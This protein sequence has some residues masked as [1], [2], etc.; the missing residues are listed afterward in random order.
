M[1]ITVT[2]LAPEIGAEISGWR[3]S[4]LVNEAVAADCKAALDQYGVLVYREV[5]I[6]DGDL[7]R[8]SR[9]LGEVVV[10][11][12]ND[13]GEH[14]EIARITLDPDKSVLAGYR[15]GNFLWHI[16][17][18]T[19][20]LPQKATLL[21]AHEVDPAGGDTQFANTYAAYDALSDEEKAE[22]AD[23][24]V[25][26]SFATAQRIAY[27]DATDKQR[28]S[29]EKV[30]TRVH[31]LVW[32]RANGRKS[33]LIGAT[34]GTVVGWP[35]D[36]G[37]ALLD[38]LLAWS[39]SPRFTLRHRWRRG[40]LVIWDNTGMLHRALPFEPTSRRLMHRTTLV[41]QELVTTR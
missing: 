28:A 41:G 36:R 17:G 3:G 33:L 8:F 38:R 20:E 39:T 27:P 24:R 10:P 31:P 9:L 15:Q 30:P 23:L 32:T 29:W 22:I 6:E 26:H 2:R 13:P 21:T 19:D 18:A 34:A 25:A 35:E 5:H 40:D 12:V 4:D 11:K 37:R 1:S 16:D 7:V 14:P